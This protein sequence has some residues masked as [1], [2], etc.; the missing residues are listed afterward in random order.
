M[1]NIHTNTSNNRLNHEFP[2]CNLYELLCFSASKIKPAVLFTIFL[3]FRS[4]FSLLYQIPLIHIYIEVICAPSFHNFRAQFYPVRP[5]PSFHFHANSRPPCLHDPETQVTRP[6]H[7]IINNDQ[8]AKKNASVFG[9]N[10]IARFRC[11]YRLPQ[12]R[13]TLNHPRIIRPPA[14]HH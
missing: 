13:A 1:V 6:T 14:R 10:N 2:Q 11:R 5:Q 9:G 7:P 12:P 8:E 4:I 3:H